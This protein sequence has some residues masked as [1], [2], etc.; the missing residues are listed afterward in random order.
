MEKEEV[1]IQAGQGGYVK[2]DDWQLI[3]KWYDRAG[4]LTDVEYHLKNS[5]EALEKFIFELDWIP[6]I[7]GE[8]GSE[9]LAYRIAQ[10]VTSFLWNTAK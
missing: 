3:K 5:Q 7:A 6:F 2:W 8:L 4:S 1:L 9:F 10:G